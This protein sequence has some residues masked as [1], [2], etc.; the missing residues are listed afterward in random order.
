M[1]GIVFDIK[2][3]AIHDGPGT[4]TTIFLKGCPLSCWWCHNPESI[5]PEIEAFVSEEKVGAEVFCNTK[6]VGTLMTVYEVME[7]IKKEQIFMNESGGG[8]TLS[9]GEPLLQFEFAL[10]LLKQCKELD[11]H[12]TLDTSG[13]TSQHKLKEMAP[14][15]DLF[16]Y[17]V[18]LFDSN[19]HKEYCGVANEIIKSNL[20]FLIESNHRVIVRIPIIPTINFENEEELNILKYLSSIRKYN[21]KEVHLLPYH[22]IGKSKYARFQKEDRLKELPELTKTELKS[23]AEK[24]KEAGFKVIV[25]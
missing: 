23:L 18:K 20:E 21:F 4:R 1:Q 16:L 7:Q 24:Y 15:V 2:R 12:T 5:S 9:G 13:F 25:H 3:F 22:N 10:E 8:L 6:N 14:F 19:I 17:D 11:I